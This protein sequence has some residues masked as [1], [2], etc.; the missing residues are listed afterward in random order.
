MSLIQQALSLITGA[1]VKSKRPLKK[2]TERQ[3]IE[4]ESEIGRDLFGPI[5]ADH[6]REFFCLDENTWVWHEE[7]TD[8]ET[9]Q[10]RSTTTRYEVHSNGILKAQD[11]INYRFIEGQE[12]KNFGLA[13]RL[14]YEQVMRGI[15]KIDPY[16]GKQITDEP[17]A[18][19]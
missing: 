7:W 9:G 19:I 4:L 6:R 1:P 10:P 5:P 3:L 17:P 16:T 8:V 2:M 15:Y 18:T 14:Y 12:M 13:V 11:G